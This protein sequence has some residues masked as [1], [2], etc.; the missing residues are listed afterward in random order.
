MSPLHDPTP[1][2]RWF[3]AVLR[4]AAATVATAMASS[5]VGSPRAEA[6]PIRTAFKNVSPL[7]RAGVSIRNGD[8]IT[9]QATLHDGRRGIPNQVIKFFVSI[10]N[11]QVYVGS[12][13][14][15]ANG[16]ASVRPRIVIP[17]LVGRN[18]VPV[19]WVPE[20]TA[21][22]PYGPAQNN[23]LGGGFRVYP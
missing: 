13:R 18:W 23:L 2:R 12:A 3:A 19:S 9:L 10:N 6:S 11:R 20:F 22:G 8:S 14:T 5:L 21:S 7:A 16:Q 17:G 4:P 1:R 15:D